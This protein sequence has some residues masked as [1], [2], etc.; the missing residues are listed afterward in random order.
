MNPSRG[1]RKRA[2]FREC[3]HMFK[4][5]QVHSIN[6]SLNSGSK[7]HGRSASAAAC[8]QDI[9]NISIPSGA[10]QSLKHASAVSA[11]V[12][13]GALLSLSRLS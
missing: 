9:L 6:R 3:N 11:Q 12:A 10:P 5:A 4:L 8:P 1:A 13:V 2:L 7:L